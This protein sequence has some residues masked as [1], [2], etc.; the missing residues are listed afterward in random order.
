MPDFVVAS[1]GRNLALHYDS[2][3]TPLGPMVLAASSYGLSHA[4]FESVDAALVRLKADYPNAEI[5]RQHDPHHLAAMRYFDAAHVPAPIM[6][7]LKGTP[8]QRMV[9]RELL[10]VPAGEVSTY[11]KIATQISK[12]RATR[13]VG[14]A[15]GRNP[16]SFFIPC[17]RILASNGG[18]GGYYWGLDKKREILAWEAETFSA[19][20]VAL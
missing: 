19:P 6:L 5:T 18:L 13:A 1:G 14:S 9:W 3:D 8:F 2:F 7:V 17:H 15:V 11:K 12:P 16:V 4:V 20:Q 10:K